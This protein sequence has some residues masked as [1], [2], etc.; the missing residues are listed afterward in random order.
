MT[1][2]CAPLV[3][4][5]IFA[6][7]YNTNNHIYYV[8]TCVMTFT[9]TPLCVHSEVCASGECCHCIYNVV[10]T[11]WLRTSR[12]HSQTCSNHSTLNSFAIRLTCW[13]FAKTWISRVL[14]SRTAR[15]T[16]CY[17]QPCAW[18]GPENTSTL[19]QHMCSS[20]ST[21]T[22]LQHRL[23]PQSCEQCRVST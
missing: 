4:H 9:Q 11:M 1:T 5:A 2:F 6:R 23:H 7:R 8:C 12:A 10:H 17:A 18:S 3:E 22:H 19:C 21:L 14:P 20:T 16:T 13:R 15:P